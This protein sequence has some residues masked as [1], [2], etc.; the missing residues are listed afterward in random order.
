MSY[1]D[2]KS[3][4]IMIDG[5]EDCKVVCFSAM[6][7][8]TNEKDKKKLVEAIKYTVDHLNLNA[9][10]VYT[11]TPH[12]DKIYEI[13]KYAIDNNVKIIIPDNTIRESNR[14]KLNG[15]S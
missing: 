13:F 15:K 5:I 3:F 14:R 10:V 8:L 11:S 4:E 2:E 12:N 1:T 6:S 7:C 9:I